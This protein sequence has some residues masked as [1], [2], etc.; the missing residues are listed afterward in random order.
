MIR[1]NKEKLTIEAPVM[2]RPKETIS[3]TAVF[4]FLALLFLIFSSFIIYLRYSNF[5]PLANLYALKPDIKLEDQLPLS[6]QLKQSKNTNL[7]LT[8]TEREFCSLAGVYSDDFPLKNATCFIKPE[9]VTVSGKTSDKFWSPKLDI[10]IR[11][12]AEND[13]LVFEI[14]EAKIWGVSAPESLANPI[15]K[16]LNSRLL[17]VLPDSDNVKVSEVRSMVGYIRVEGEKK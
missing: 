5:S 15:F 12:K 13:K 2:T 4:V 3:V 10:L 1:N 14:K 8:I 17:Q 6:L 16:D 9:G 7:E 11:P